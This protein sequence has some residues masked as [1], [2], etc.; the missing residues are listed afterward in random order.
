[1]RCLTGVDLVS[2]QT[3]L[4]QERNFGGHELCGAWAPVGELA[5]CY[6]VEG[7]MLDYLCDTPHAQVTVVALQLS[8]KVAE[9]V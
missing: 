1:M 4:D 2:R 8:S 7:L 6:M 5:L 9:S 3:Y